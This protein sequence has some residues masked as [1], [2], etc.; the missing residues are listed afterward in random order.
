[1]LR[2]R[3]LFAAALLGAALPAAAQDSTI[4]YQGQLQEAN[5]PFTGTANLQF[6]LFDQPTNGSQVGPTETRT[7]WP[8]EDGLFQVD[9]DFGA[10]AFD[11]SARFLEVWVNG[12]PLSPRQAIRA[13]PVALFA[14]GGNEG[15]EGPA[16]PD[17]DP[18]PQGESGPAGPKGDPGPAG[19]QGD[20]GPIGP[21]GPQGPQGPQGEPGPQG[22]QGNPGPA[23]PEGVSPFELISDNA[24]FTAGNVG[25]GTDEPSAR[26]QVFGSVVLGSS[27][28][29]ATG[30]AS[31]ASGLDDFDQRN[32]ATGTASFVAGGTANRAHGNQSFVG[33]GTGLL[34]DGS[35]SFVAGGFLN[36]SSGTNSFTAGNRARALHDNTFV[37]SDGDGDVFASTGEDQFLVRAAGGVGI[38]TNEP[39]TNLHLSGLNTSM[40]NPDGIRL[41]NTTGRRWDI[42][43]STSF[44]RFNFDSGDGVSNNVAWVNDANGSWNT[45]SDR[46]LK[47]EIRPLASV[48]ERIAALEVVDYQFRRDASGDTRHLGLIAQNVAEHFPE[49]TDEAEN[50][51]YL[52]VNYAGFSVIA[53]KAIQEQ[54]A[55]IEDQRDRLAVLQVEMATINTQTEQLQLLADRN[56]ELEAR[57]IALEALLLEDRSLATNR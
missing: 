29:I 14:L 35:D 20:P 24:V 30:A 41:E 31:F 15:P 46:R 50:N 9:L 11:G 56:A 37:W 8:V 49:L 22:Q 55:I 32:E 33:G 36:I 16:G 44:L 47:K 43:T 25:V 5:Q 45:P 26:L 18:G 19:P 57:L 2:Y 6:Q 21:A 48:L 34:A 40:D 12:A 53:L 3:G 4:T 42:H 28:N 23:G 1:M 17:G 51:G 39:A 52:G 38:N 27:T 7:N 13:A 54:Q 10:S